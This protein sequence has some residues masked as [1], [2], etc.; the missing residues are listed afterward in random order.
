MALAQVIMVPEIIARIDKGRAIVKNIL[1]RESLS[2][3][4]LLMMSLS[5]FSNPVLADLNRKGDATK[6]SAMIT[7][8]VLPGMIN[9]NLL[10][11]GPNMP[12]GAK[13]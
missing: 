1:R 4:A 6:H 13:A 3:L 9:P 8:I 5:M 10:K 2:I 11:M 7:A 12:L